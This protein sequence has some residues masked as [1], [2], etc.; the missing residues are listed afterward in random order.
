MKLWR[1]IAIAG[2]VAMVLSGAALAGGV[3]GTPHDMSGEGWNTEGEICLP[4]HI[5]HHSDTTVGFLWNHEVPDA[6]AFTMHSTND[7]LAAESLVCLG[8]H[9]GVTV[10]DSYSGKTGGTTMSGEE[11]I[12][13]DLTDDHPVG[14]EYGSNS[15]Y[16]PVG[17]MWGTHPGIP[18]GY[19]G[20]PLYGP[21]ADGTATIECATCHTPHSNTYDNFLRLD[22]TGSALCGA[23]H[24]SHMGP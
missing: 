8:C 1:F 6:S 2:V 18:V 10:I 20:L 9:D 12:G 5:P 14:I 16:A 24:T 22:N 19:G 21:V 4:C 7:V 3:Q 15:R 13:R 23:C 11:N 17:T